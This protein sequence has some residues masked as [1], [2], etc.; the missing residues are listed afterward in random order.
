MQRGRT[1]V[2][3]Q[4]AGVLLGYLGAVLTSALSG[5]AVRRIVQEGRLASLQEKK[6]QRVASR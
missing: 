2:E 4:H 1:Q 6:E 3:D 5:L